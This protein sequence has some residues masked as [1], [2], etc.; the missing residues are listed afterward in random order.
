LIIKYRMK[1]LAA[2]EYEAICITRNRQPIKQPFDEVVS[3]YVFVSFSGSNRKVE[4]P[5]FNTV[6]LTYTR[7]ST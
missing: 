2:L 6:S 5:C 1:Q 3:L 4:Q 7:A